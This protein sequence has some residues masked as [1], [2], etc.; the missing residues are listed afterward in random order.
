[1]AGRTDIEKYIVTLI[2]IMIHCPTSSVFSAL[3]QIKASG[4]KIIASQESDINLTTSAV[5]PGSQGAM[6]PDI[7]ECLV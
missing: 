3:V 5:Q 1:M 2:I 4:V 7:E 6:E